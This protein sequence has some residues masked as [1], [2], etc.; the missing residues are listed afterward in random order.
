MWV[1]FPS[2]APLCPLMAGSEHRRMRILVSAKSCAAFFLQ[3]RK[4]E[5]LRRRRAHI[6]HSQCPIGTRLRARSARNTLETST[7]RNAP[8]SICINRVPTIGRCHAAANP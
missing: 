7:G 3:V 5:D 4:S 2:P 6:A 8:S 1:R